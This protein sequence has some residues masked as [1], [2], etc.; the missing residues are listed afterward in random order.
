MPRWKKR[1]E[2]YAYA[3][4]G[5]T[6]GDKHLRAGNFRGKKEGGANG[7]VFVDLD[8]IDAYYES[9]PDVKRADEGHH[10]GQAA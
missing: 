5:R 7:A 10:Q 2:A 6:V 3:G 4:C 1:L 8:S 9:L